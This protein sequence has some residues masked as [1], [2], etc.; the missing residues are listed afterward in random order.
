MG[1]MSR[2]GDFLRNLIGRGP[3]EAG[4]PEVNARHAET[5]H[6]PN[7][8]SSFHLIWESFI[9][10][11]P[12]PRLAEVSAVLEVIEPPGV[13]ALYFWA[14]QVDLADDRGVWGGGHTGLQ[15][16]RR[17]PGGRAVNWG[18]YRSPEQGGQVLAGTL[19]SLP[20]FSGDPNTLTYAW[21][22]GRPYRL[23]V[24]RSPDIV[25][26]W[27]A[28]VTDLWS[29]VSTVIR[30]LLPDAGRGVAGSYLTRP[31]VWSEVFADCE[32]PSV[33]VRWS[34]LTAVDEGGSVVRPEAVRVNYQSPQD[35][36][37]SNTTALAD[38]NG[39]LL[40]VTNVPRL[41]EQGAVLPL[42]GSARSAQ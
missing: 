1:P 10:P 14:L 3:R 11:A 39:G 38:E 6:S 37:C 41:V 9:G 28:E 13:E 31:I 27:R 35:G 30:D 33:T 23:R 19:S 24:Y 8:A 32:A 5:R 7:G 22:T 12:H 18:G 40:Q 34:D 26:A 42:S 16:N 21:E 17:Y 20:G 36:G 25:G 4:A 15:W 2:L 29:G